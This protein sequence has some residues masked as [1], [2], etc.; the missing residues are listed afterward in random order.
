MDTDDGIQVIKAVKSH[1]R[2]RPTKRIKTTMGMFTR[3][4]APN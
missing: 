3:P 1:P 4:R 2:P